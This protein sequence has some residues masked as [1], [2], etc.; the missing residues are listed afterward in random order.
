[1]LNDRI[2]VTKKHIEAANVVVDEILPKLSDKYLMAIGG[3]VGSGKST[4]AFAIAHRLKK[5]GVRCKIIDL[6]DFYLV[7]PHS[8]KAWRRKYGIQS[9]GPSEYDWDAINL[10]IQDFQDSSESSMPCVDLITGEVD[11]LSTSFKGI[12]VALFNGLYATMLWQADFK[13]FLEL[14][15]RETFEAQLFGEKEE[16][17]E[18]RKQ[19]LEREHKMVQALK[20]GCHMFFDFD[21]MLDKYHL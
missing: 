13:V 5:E 18:F 12:Q 17:T 10:V 7:A 9:I 16:M 20:A 14:T 8:R 1:M 4:L 2:T 3:E 19:I 21:A 6:D 15:Y 11:R